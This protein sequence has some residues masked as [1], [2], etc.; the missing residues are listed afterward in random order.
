MFLSKSLKLKRDIWN[1]VRP[2]LALCWVFCNKNCSPLSL[3]PAPSFLFNLPCWIT[4][5]IR[6]NRKIKGWSRNVKN[7]FLQTHLH[8]P[9]KCNGWGAG[10][11]FVRVHHELWKSSNTWVIA[12]NHIWHLGVAEIIRVK[13]IVCSCRATDKALGFNQQFQKLFVLYCSRY[14]RWGTLSKY[15]RVP[16]QEKHWHTGTTESY[17]WSEVCASASFT[18]WMPVVS[19]WVAFYQNSPKIQSGATQRWLMISS[20]S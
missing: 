8:S 20:A 2:T 4:A 9:Q 7:S 11:P 19:V 15:F 5:L 10:S 14:G 3:E 1:I 18:F 16:I 12:T 17:I 6:F 13:V